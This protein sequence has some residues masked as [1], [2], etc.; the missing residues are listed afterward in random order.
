MGW[1]NKTFRRS[2][3]PVDFT[4][5]ADLNKRAMQF[6]ARG[7]Y[8]QAEPLLKRALA[9]QEKDF[10]SN[11][12]ATVSNLGSLANLYA[13]QGQYAQA[14]SFYRRALVTQEKTLGPDH[15]KIAMLLENI[16]RIYRKTGREQ[17]AEG[18]ARR[19]VTILAG[20]ALHS[21]REKRL[22]IAAH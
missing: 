21:S 12:P 8:A 3:E 10:G 20:A 19:A 16:A 17:E 15:P 14:E 6:L 18:L 4:E 1:A 2:A 9:I 22:G 7:R 5:A 11:H 13:L